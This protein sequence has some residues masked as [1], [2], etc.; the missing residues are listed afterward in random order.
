[1]PIVIFLLIDLLAL[2][3][4][5]LG[6]SRPVREL[7]FLLEEGGDDIMQHSSILTRPVL[8]PMLKAAREN[9][10]CDGY[11]MPILFVAVAAV[12][13]VIVPL[14]L[15]ATAERK[16]RYFRQLGAQFAAS[17]QIIR[18]AVML[19]ESWFV[20]AKQA[21]AASQVP[22]SRHP[23]RQEA[24]FL[25]GRNTDKSRNTYVIEP[26]TRDGNNQPVWEKRPFAV[27][28]EPAEAARH[29]S[30]LLDYLFLA[31]RR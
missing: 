12:A 21:P 15:P 2:G 31:N 20:N 27:F 19:S 5:S 17:G 22:P 8:E 25:M 29:V 28:N 18:E 11:L 7:K 4:F 16:E 14:E 26:F 3:L 6:A 24:I 30:G 1:M 13:P 9:L 10:M 23:C